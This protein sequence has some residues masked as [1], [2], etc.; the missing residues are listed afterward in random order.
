LR[1]LILHS[2]CFACFWYFHDIQY[3]GMLLSANWDWCLRSLCG[4]SSHSCYNSYRLLPTYSKLQTY[5][6][7]YPPSLQCVYKQ[8]FNHCTTA[9][10]S[11]MSIHECNYFTLCHS[12]KHSTTTDNL[13]SHVLHSYSNTERKEKGNYVI[14]Y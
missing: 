3:H 6:W 12:Q 10:I 13:Y 14:N 5:Q 8:Y 2:C 11:L 1:C 4:S 7:D 9:L